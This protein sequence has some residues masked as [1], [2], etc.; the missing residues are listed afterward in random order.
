[1]NYD[2]LRKYENLNVRK[3][4]MS[5]PYRVPGC[6]GYP[7]VLVNFLFR[8]WKPSLKH[9]TKELIGGHVDHLD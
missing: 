7:L 9:L 6:D 8:V 4:K 3:V 2:E 1:M 5:Y